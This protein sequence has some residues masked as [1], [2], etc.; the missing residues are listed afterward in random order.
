MRQLYICIKYPI[1]QRNCKL[2]E[3]RAISKK[4][5]KLEINK[6]II[7]C[8]NTF[9]NVENCKIELRN[10]FCKLSWKKSCLSKILNKENGNCTKIKE[11][12]KNI[13]IIKDGA[14]LLSGNHTVD[15]NS[16]E[17]VY[18][19]IFENKTIIDNITYENPTSKIWNYIRTTHI[20]NYI[21]TKYM[22]SDNKD[23]KFEN[24]N[25]MSKLTKHIE[26]HPFSIF[27]LVII[28]VTTCVI[29]NKYIKLL[30][31]KKLS[32]RRNQDEIMFDNI[33]KRVIL[34]TKRLEEEAGRSS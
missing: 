19:I 15:N 11:K 1:I 3:T 22:D 6:E 28:I 14:I 8:N 33:N 23:L 9:L 10:T 21:I 4:G 13:E 16:I 2:Y 5:G 25:L 18:L 29:L 7:K 12:N 24:I 26:N 31:L 17:G 32:K 30:Y 20:N 27:L 34:L